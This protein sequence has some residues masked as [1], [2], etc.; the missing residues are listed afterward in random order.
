MNDNERKKDE[1]LQQ[2]S[3]LSFTS[4]GRKRKNQIMA[5]PSENSSKSS[6]KSYWGELVR[7]E[8]RR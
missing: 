7:S 3:R 6:R 8:E 4:F 1:R 2:I 5:D